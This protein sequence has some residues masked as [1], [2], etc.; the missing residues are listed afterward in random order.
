MIMLSLLV[1][2]LRKKTILTLALSRKSRGRQAE[3]AIILA[4]YFLLF[5]K[6]CVYVQHIAI[7]RKKE[8][9]R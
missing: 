7:K 5:L 4:L 6:S 2:P 9:E 1:S 8:K 3:V